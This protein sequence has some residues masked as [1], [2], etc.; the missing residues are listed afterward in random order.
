MLA[1][2][3]GLAAM[4]IDTSV[5]M[6]AARMALAGAPGNGG[7]IAVLCTA[8]GISAFAAADQPG[9]AGGSGRFDSCPICQHAAGAA[10]PPAYIPALLPR[11]F[12]ASVYTIPPAERS[13]GND[14]FQTL[15][16]RGPP[17]AALSTA[18]S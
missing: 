11:S 13:A 17:P 1:A 12:A 4:F 15:N 10:C 8:L 2:L 5:H 7:R 6:L 3:L 9:T 14:V 18:I 16:N